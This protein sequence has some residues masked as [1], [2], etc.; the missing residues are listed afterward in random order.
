VIRCEEVVKDAAGRVAELRCTYDPATGGGA[1]PGGRRVKGTIHW[2]SAAHAKPAVARLYGT[3]FSEPDP[4]KVEGGADWKSFLNPGSLEAIEGCRV[5]PALADV[6]TGAAVQFERQGYF[7]RDPDSTPER[8]VFNRT[9][10][11]RD[12]WAKIAARG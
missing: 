10:S 4:T 1:A 12:T 9:V 8:A 5:E 11:L 3:L 7:C 6:A 2:V